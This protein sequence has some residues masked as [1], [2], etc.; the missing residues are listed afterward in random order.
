[1]KYY[2]ILLLFL[3]LGTSLG[4]RAQKYGYLNSSQIIMMHPDVKAADQKLVNYQ[5]ELIKVGEDM[6]KKLE[7]NYNA[8]VQEANSGTLSKI[9]MQE[10]ET[11]LAQEQEAI[12]QYEVE[13]QQKILIKREELYKPILDKIDA[14]VKAVG[15]ENG[16]N[17]IFDTSGGAIL[18][19][20]ESDDIF[21][22]VKAKL[23]L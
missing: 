15:Q 21:E 12:R 8:Y 16:Y 1:M 17:M 22:L 20:T 9:Q 11:K 10:K 23:N 4:L 13:V 5:T 7:S 3:F 18:H 2:T 6:A 14:A 19:A